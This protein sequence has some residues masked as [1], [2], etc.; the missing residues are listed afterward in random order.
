MINTLHFLVWGLVG[1][2]VAINLFECKHINGVGSIYK[3]YKNTSRKV[4]EFERQKEIPFEER[5]I[6]QNALFEREKLSSSIK[7]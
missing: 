6:A 1:S 4:R 2:S 5:H 7:F 3:T